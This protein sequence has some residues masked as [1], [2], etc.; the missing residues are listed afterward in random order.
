MAFISE[1]EILKDIQRIFLLEKER[2]FGGSRNEFYQL[3]DLFLLSLI[4][5][6]MSESN[7]YLPH[8]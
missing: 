3:T 4:L 8:T 5:N 6:I 1:P 7:I 2:H